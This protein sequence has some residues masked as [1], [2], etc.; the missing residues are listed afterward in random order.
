M[1]WSWLLV[2]FVGGSLLGLVTM[3]VV[4]AGSE[5]ERQKELA[6][7]KRRAKGLDMIAA[8]LVGSGDGGFEADDNALT[9]LWDGGS[10]TLGRAPK[11]ELARSLVGLIVRRRA[12]P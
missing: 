2:A 6:E 4:S 9:I 11:V 7:A 8:N 3:C 1:H 12:Q 5:T 10:E